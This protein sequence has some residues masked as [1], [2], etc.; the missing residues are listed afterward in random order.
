MRESS[1]DRHI[2]NVAAA[3]DGEAEALERLVRGIQPELYRLA[4]RFF[5]DPRDA[6]DATQEALVQVVTRLDR[7]NGESAFST[8]V[9]RVATNKFLSLARSQGERRALS[10]AEF[11]EELSRVPSTPAEATS[12]HVADRLL[13][14]EVKIGCTLA[15]LLCLDRGHRMA[16]ILGEIMELDHATGA[17]ILD[18]SAAAFR[19]RLQ[20]SRT[21][22]TDLMRARCGLIDRRNACRCR[23]RVPVAVERGCVD[24]HDLVFASSKEQARQFPEVLREIRR[25]EEAD[26]AGA[27]Y[28][29]HPDT[30]STVDLAT[31]VH[32]LFDPGTS[33]ATGSAPT[34]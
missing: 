25:L 19:K 31:F 14:E 7:F 28:R 34:R 24:P 33:A 12:A 23:L 3:T 2:D 32:K 5:G 20:R 21:R 17:A 26:R 11:D 29:S 15:M 4:V 13:L 1:G 8:W 27:L 6:E 16:Y 22:I 30:R 18:I 9:Y 10:L